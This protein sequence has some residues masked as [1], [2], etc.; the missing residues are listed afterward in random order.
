M[1]EIETLKTTQVPQLD[2]T[3]PMIS[4]LHMENQFHLLSSIDGER[5]ARW[6]LRLIHHL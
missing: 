1:A 4:P 5:D 2:T 6:L 3:L